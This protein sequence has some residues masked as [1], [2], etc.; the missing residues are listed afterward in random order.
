MSLSASPLEIKQRCNE[1]PLLIKR[2]RAGCCG[3]GPTRLIHE[4][5]CVHHHFRDE[6]S[7]LFTE[8]GRS[9]SD[10]VVTLHCSWSAILNNDNNN[11]IYWEIMEGNNYCKGNMGNKTQ[12]VNLLCKR[13]NSPKIRSVFFRDWLGQMRYCYG[14]IMQEHRNYAAVHGSPSPTIACYHTI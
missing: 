9:S 4:L 14:M 11:K 12:G 13:F 10:Q 6:T 2:G 8:W 7:M 1:V 5:Q 3:G